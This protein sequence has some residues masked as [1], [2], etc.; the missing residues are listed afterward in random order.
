MANAFMPSV[1]AS[2]NAGGQ[3]SLEDIMKRRLFE[4]QLAQSNLGLQRQFNA[5]QEQSRRFDA[6]ERYQ[7][8]IINARM[9]AVDAAQQKAELAANTKVGQ[10]EAYQQAV[11]QASA[12]YEAGDM[13]TVRRLVA[14][15]KLPVSIFAEK[16]APRDPV[17][18]AYDTT[19]A[20]RRADADARKQGLIPTKAAKGE[21][22]AKDTPGAP[23]A[24]RAA[25]ANRKGTTG[26]EN[27][28]AAKASI[29]AKWDTWRQ[30]YPNLD[31]SDVS[32]AIANLYGTRPKTDGGMDM[33]AI[34]ARVLAKMS[35]RP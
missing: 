22:P 16:A 11:E 31:E 25:L 24:F 4:Q 13:P 10:A 15:F 33:A 8:G 17:Q 1:A 23:A 9:A 6:Q 2:L 3:A 27:A 14:Q 12:A 32:S 34:R 7:Q 29:R 20:R 28:D 18:D 35:A 5:D 21:K 19:M 30:N 26:F